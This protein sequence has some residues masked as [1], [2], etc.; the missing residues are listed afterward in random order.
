MA[1]S[2][3]NIQSESAKMEQIITEFFAKSL[4]IILES[5]S[6]YV[7]SRNFSGEQ[8]LSSPSSSTS[9]SSSVR[10]RDKWFNLAL[11]DC[12]AALENID[13]WRQSNFEPMVVDVVLVQR[14]R[15]WNPVNISPRPG[16]VR[17]LSLKERFPNCWNSDR[18]DVNW[19]SKSEKIIERW[20]IQYENRKNSC[21]GSKRSSTSS[22]HTLYK[23][24]I[25]LMRSLYLTVRLLPAY[26]LFHDLNSSNQLRS[27]ALA[28]R[29]SSFVEPFTRREEAEMQRFGFG[30]VETTCGRLCVSVLFHSSVLDLSSE[31]TTPMSP[32][33]I[34]DYVGSPLTD[35]LKRF[36]SLPVTRAMTQ[37]SLGSSPFSR[38]H[39]WSYDNY[40]AS[41]P[42]ISFSPS[43]TYSDSRAI[44]SRANPSRPPPMS[45]PPHPPESST[46]ETRSIH[47]DEYWPSPS[48]SPSTSSSPS[49][50]I[51][52]PPFSKVLDRSGSAPVTIPAIKLVHSPSLLNR[53]A[54][55]PSPP[56]KG[57]Q[58][59]TSRSEK[60]STVI[61]KLSFGRG[62][63]EN[64]SGEKV[65]NTLTRTFSRSSSRLSLQE[66]FDDADFACPFDMDDDDVTNPG[67]SSHQDAAVGTLVRILKKAPPLR[68]DMSKSLVASSV[69]APNISSTISPPTIPTKTT[70]DALEE[71]QG[72]RE[73]KALLLNRSS[74]FEKD[75]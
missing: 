8:V 11:R 51:P 59:R 58:L 25:L 22:L 56:P 39:S 23:K 50:H 49:V 27:F 44:V 14:P 9:S 5:R 30:P 26:K 53:N 18:E 42:C 10:P 6:A 67:S 74:K 15:D 71:L 38:R 68:Q 48:F 64:A 13:F 65:S 75:P 60:S 61:D 21:S 32:Q 55:I 57:P 28:H 3:G 70:C 31:P 46:A 19:D 33:F 34:P 73:M 62:D 37:G 1:S 36:P 7:S 17:N 24:S 72:Y 54:V 2:H 52:G 63:I 47:F 45:M 40:R 41:P 66:D 16:L 29:V 35:T 4:H 12:P 20:I 43:P 69:N